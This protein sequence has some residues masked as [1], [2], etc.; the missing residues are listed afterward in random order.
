[1]PHFILSTRKQRFAKTK[2]RTCPT[3]FSHGFVF[4]HGFASRKASELVFSDECL[5]RFAGISR[6]SQV[7]LFFFKFLSPTRFRQKVVLLPTISRT[8]VLK[9]ANHF[10]FFQI[11]TWLQASP[12]AI[13][14][15]LFCNSRKACP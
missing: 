9:Q 10:D 8:A 12:N 3:I 14:F 7:K 2:V 13:N 4:E 11:G 1:M 15:A 5:G 6:A